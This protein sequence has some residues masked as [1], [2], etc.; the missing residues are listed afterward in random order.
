MVALNYAGLSGE[1]LSNI[2][3]ESWNI[4]DFDEK[5]IVTV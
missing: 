4:T 2:L 1:S 5:K 3:K